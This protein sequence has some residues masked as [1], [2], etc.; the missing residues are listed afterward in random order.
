M[1]LYSVLAQFLCDFCLEC[2]PTNSILFLRL[3][4]VGLLSSN[5]NSTHTIM[6]ISVI[7]TFDKKST[8]LRKSMDHRRVEVRTR[9]VCCEKY[10]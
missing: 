9:I 6:K 3:I 2:V 1:Y 4:F 10:F 5:L 8:K 7:Q